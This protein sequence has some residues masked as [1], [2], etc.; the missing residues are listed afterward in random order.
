M[1]VTGIVKF[2][3]QDKGFDARTVTLLAPAEPGR[4]LLR[5]W[6]GEN[7]A[8]LAQ[9]DIEI[10]P[11]QV[12]LDAPSQVDMARPFV[13]RWQGPGAVR[14]DVE[15]VDPADNKRLRRQRLNQDRGFDRHEVTLTAPAV[16][17]RTSSGG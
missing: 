15:I 11:M 3:N 7:E 5:Y 9:R 10:V 13:V 8:V 4:Y 12:A 17:G 1:A 6:N 16:P 2:F 14:D